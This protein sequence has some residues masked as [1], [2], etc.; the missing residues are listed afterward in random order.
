M[1]LPGSPQ[2]CFLRHENQIRYPFVLAQG[3]RHDVA[4]AEDLSALLGFAA[5]LLGALRQP[6]CFSAPVFPFCLFRSTASLGR[7]NGLDNVVCWKFGPWGAK[8]FSFEEAGFDSYS[9]FFLFFSPMKEQNWFFLLQDKTKKA[10][11]TQQDKE[12]ENSLSRTRRKSAAR[13]SIQG[14]FVPLVQEPALLQQY[15]P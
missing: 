6:L 12:G 5:C 1:A 14:V 11:F 10:P 3:R 4:E 2:E 13:R 15:I 9:L 7:G 8:A